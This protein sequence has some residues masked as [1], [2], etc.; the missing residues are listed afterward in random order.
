MASF[1]WTLEPWNECKVA[2]QFSSVL[3]S[4]EAK[5]MEIYNAMLH[6]LEGKKCKNNSQSH[7]FLRSLQIPPFP[8]LLHSSGEKPSI[9]KLRKKRGFES[10]SNRSN[11]FFSLERKK[12]K[13]D[14]D[15]HDF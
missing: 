11:D 4:I 9:F 2:W 15:L 5:R 13:K 7:V 8:F 14:I 1:I 6:I 3:L 12:C 10:C